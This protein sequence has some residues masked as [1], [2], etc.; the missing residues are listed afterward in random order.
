MYAKAGLSVLLHACYAVTCVK[1]CNF[2]DETLSFGIADCEQKHETY[3]KM[4]TEEKIMGLLYCG[5]EQCVGM[6]IEKRFY[7]PINY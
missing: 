5:W 4:R 7:K 2:Y 3:T 6:S 1:W